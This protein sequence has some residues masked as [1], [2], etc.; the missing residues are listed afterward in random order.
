MTDRSKQDAREISSAPAPHDHQGRPLS[1][2][3][4]D[5]AGMPFDD[6]RDQ[7]DR[8]LQFLRSSDRRLDDPIGFIAKAA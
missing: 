1:L 8:R 6:S 2:V 4:Q 5:T 7:G 3:Q